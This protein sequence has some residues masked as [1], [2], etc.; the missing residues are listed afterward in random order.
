LLAAAV[1][2]EQTKVV[3]VVPVVLD[4]QRMNL[5]LQQ[6]TA[7]PLELVELAKLVMLELVVVALLD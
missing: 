1:A 2:V 6:I 5:Y 7:L 4:S 3:P